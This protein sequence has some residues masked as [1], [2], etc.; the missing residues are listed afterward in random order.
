MQNE[1]GGKRERLWH[2]RCGVP[3]L[4]VTH[5]VLSKA[6]RAK[7]GT[8]S[9]AY[10]ANSLNELGSRVFPESPSYS[11]GRLTPWFWSSKFCSRE[12]SQAHLDSSPTE[13]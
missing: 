13:R 1:V 12:T 3:S 7:G 2:E 5:G 4:A 8:K 9:K 11:P 10:V 6:S